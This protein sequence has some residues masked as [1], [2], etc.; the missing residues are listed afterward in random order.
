[1]DQQAIHPIRIKPRQPPIDRF[2]IDSVK[3]ADTTEHYAPLAQSKVKLFGDGEL[4][5]T[6]ESGALVRSTYI[7]HPTFGAGLRFV[8]LTDTIE[9]DNPRLADD[10]FGEPAFVPYYATQYDPELSV[11]DYNAAR[12]EDRSPAGWVCDGNDVVFAHMFIPTCVLRKVANGRSTPLG[13]M[14]PM[15]ALMLIHASIASEDYHY[16]DN[17]VTW[18]AAP[19]DDWTAPIAGW[20]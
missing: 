20:E 7:W 16:P 2:R 1:M 13:V 9:A 12:L 11:M 18:L 19:V 10:P 17:D 4:Q 15:V 3:L 14:V 6:H 5:M 8:L